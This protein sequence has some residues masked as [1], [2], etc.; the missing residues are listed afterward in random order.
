V[1]SK[2]LTPAPATPASASVD[3]G[4]VVQVEFDI[5]IQPPL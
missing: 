3:A 4:T 5:A 2:P 1:K